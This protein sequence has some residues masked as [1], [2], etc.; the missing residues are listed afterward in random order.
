MIGKTTMLT[1]LLLLAL[2]AMPAPAQATMQ[3]TSP[4]HV[5][6]ADS[7][8]A[9]AQPVA[10]RYLLESEIEV[11]YAV[12]CGQGGGG[13]GG[14]G[15][16]PHCPDDPDQC[17]P[18]DFED[19]DDSQ[20]CHDI[21]CQSHPNDYTCTEQAECENGFFGRD[22]DHDGVCDDDDSDDDGDGVPD[23]DDEVP[24]AN[25]PVNNAISCGLYLVND[26]KFCSGSLLG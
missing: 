3:V 16:Q 22:T 26:R 23:E 1:G 8:Q 14:G 25:D 12:P 10:L 18:C 6:I 9:G 2:V 5:C 13:G 19:P 7:T 21:H 20:M 4:P 24:Y 11:G 17:G 15:Q